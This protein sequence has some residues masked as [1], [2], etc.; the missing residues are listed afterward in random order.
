MR[1]L[2]RLNQLSENE[3]KYANLHSNTE[4]LFSVNLQIIIVTAW[5]NNRRSFPLSLLP[6]CFYVFVNRLL[7]FQRFLYPPFREARS[8]KHS[9]L[10]TRLFTKAFFVPITA[11][12]PP[13]SFPILSQMSRGEICQRAYCFPLFNPFDLLSFLRHLARRQLDWL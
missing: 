10:K 1:S 7:L 4:I 8:D 13:L 3:Q 11:I 9:L 2:S 6:K 5:C 12:F